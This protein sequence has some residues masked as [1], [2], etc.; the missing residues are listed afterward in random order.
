MHFIELFKNIVFRSVA[1]VTKKVM[2]YLNFFHRPHV[3]CRHVPYPI[4]KKTYLFNKT[5]FKLLFIKFTKFHCDSVKNESAESLSSNG[6]FDIS[7]Y[8]FQIVHF[9]V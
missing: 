6:T 2:G 3:F 1:L 7:F 8:N 9:I 5:S 4:N